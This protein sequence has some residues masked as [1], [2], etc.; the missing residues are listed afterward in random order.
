MRLSE[1]IEA[2]GSFWLPEEPDRK[3]SGVLR[4]SESGRATLELQEQNRRYDFPKD[5]DVRFAGIVDK[6]GYITLEQCQN[7]SFSVGS[8]SIWRF[9]ARYVLVGVA[10]E[11]D[12]S[13]YFEQVRFSV[14]GLDEWLGFSGFKIDHE[15]YFSNLGQLSIRFQVP[16]TIAYS[17]SGDFDLEFCFGVSY[18]SLKAVITEATIKQEAYIR[19]KSRTPIHIDDLAA[20]SLKIRNFLCLAIG[21]TVSIKTFTV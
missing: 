15:A 5:N 18:P 10:Y 17:L 20:L 14:E 6:L 7:L 4:I 19:L 3:F 21:Q 11:V 12:D 16:D 1:P 8:L 13:P 2:A 9:Y